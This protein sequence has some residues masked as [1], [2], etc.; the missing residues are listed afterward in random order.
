MKLKRRLDWLVFTKRGYSLLTHL[1]PFCIA[2]LLL[3][4]VSVPD[5]NLLIQL[6]TRLQTP[7]W[8]WAPAAM[9]TLA[10]AAVY[11]AIVFVQIR[12]AYL[13]RDGCWRRTATTTTFF[14][15]TCTSM[16]FAV[17][18]S[19]SARTPYAAT[20]W[21][22]LLLALL[23]LTGIGWSTPSS[24]IE[25][26]GIKLPDYTEPEVEV[27]RVTEIVARMRREGN[28]NK[29]D[30]QRFLEAVNSLRSE[31]EKNLKYEPGWEQ[32]NLSPIVQE[33]RN[34]HEVAQSS[35]PISDANKIKDFAVACQCQKTQYSEF[36]TALNATGK[37]WSAW[38]CA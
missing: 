1:V 9:L 20:I 34:L 25:S 22:C 37:Y 29:Q 19:A 21:A 16:A 12:R 17:L 11:F 13:F 24:W 10:T 33:L 6:A 2:A 26:L 32:A 4:I 27:Q 7:S 28:S 5:D 14:V 35:F 18:I 23:S 3:L 15:I 36:M 31:I 30:V 8:L 38:K